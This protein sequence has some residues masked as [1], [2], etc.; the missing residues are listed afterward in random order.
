MVVQE[1][2]LRII[3]PALS[4]K[5]L[6]VTSAFSNKVHP[7]SAFVETIGFLIF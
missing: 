5:A 6:P 7:C 1:N 4:N 2:M 3:A